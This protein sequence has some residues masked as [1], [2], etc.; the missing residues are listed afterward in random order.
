VQES[1]LRLPLHS[2]RLLYV[3]EVAA[4]SATGEAFQY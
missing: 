4:S 1:N 2:Q 3:I